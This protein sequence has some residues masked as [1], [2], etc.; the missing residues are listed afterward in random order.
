[1]LIPIRVILLFFYFLLTAT[2]GFLI[3]LLR[4]FNP[5]NTRIC[6][7]LFSWGSLKILGIR[8]EVEGCEHLKNLKSSIVVANHQ[9][10]Y[11]LFV[12]GKIVPRRTVSIGK[13]SLKY[14]PFF[15]QVYWLAGNILIDRSKSKESIGQMSEA[16]DALKEYDTSLWVFAEGTRNKG[17]GLLPFKKGAFHMAKQAGVPLVPICTST[18]AGHMDFHRWVS[19]RVLIRVLP[20]VQ[21]GP[22]SVNELRL[23]IRTQMLDTISDLDRRLIDSSSMPACGNQNARL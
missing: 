17:R 21:V 18:Y 10:N 2:L 4:P 12:H 6:G 20:P 3:C 22:E 14:V 15:G 9:A 1:M 5:D 7:R 8:V 13:R 16:I 23:K 11:D 19:A